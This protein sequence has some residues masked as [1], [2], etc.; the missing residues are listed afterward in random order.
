MPDEPRNFGV[1]EGK[2]DTDWI[3]GTIPFE[4]R[5]P[6]G[7]W[8]DV[9]PLEERQRFKKVETMACVSF[10][11]LSCLETQL[12]FAGKEA[13]FSDRFTAK[14]SGTTPQGN[15]LYRV[16]DSVRNIGVVPEALW[17]ASDSFNWDAYYREIPGVIIAQAQRPIVR[18]EFLLDTSKD[19]LMHELRH[20]PLQVVIPG[21]AVELFRQEADVARYFDS[22]SP[23]RKEWTSPFSQVLKMVY[24]E[25][26]ADAPMTTAE[27]IKLYVLAFYREPD[28]TELGYWTGKPLRNF[29]DTA[30]KDRAAFLKAHEA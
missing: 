5:N 10:S 13:N 23:F 25:Q 28:A 20:A 16:A 24:Y 19:S 29:L 21:H 11:L 18:Y 14:V 9:L 2:R 4:D 12:K 27:V 15:Y 17:P 6:S 8:A 30:I 26:A 22:Y 1:I 3:G 7:N